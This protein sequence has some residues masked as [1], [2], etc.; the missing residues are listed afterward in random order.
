[1]K[2]TFNFLIILSILI[3]PTFASA[4][5]DRRPEMRANISSTSTRGEFME[6]VKEKREEFKAERA[7]TTA[8]MK[9]KRASSTEELK[10]EITQKREEFR[11]ERASSIAERASTTAEIRARNASTTAK[12]KADIERF[13]VELKE[14]LAK[15]KD[16][17]KRKKVERVAN[18]LPELNT[19]LT[20]EATVTV[21]KIEAVSVAVESRT[22][23]A[24]AQNINVT[25]VRPL[26]ATAKTAIADAKAA[27]T[28]Q[29]T[30]VYSINIT[31]DATVKTTLEAART[32]MK[33]DIDAMNAKVKAARDAVKKATDALKVIPNVNATTTA[34]TATSTN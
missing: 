6:N 3:S 2:T 32:Q 10:K 33:T 22:N 18:S 9:A 30:K 8:E 25:A 11:I 21:N 26:I 5:S 19:K 20:S 34:T 12:F 1:M 29:S 27:V 15:I 28:L 17:V 16:E 23:K 14:G 4:E 7:S 13:K 24:A 31:S